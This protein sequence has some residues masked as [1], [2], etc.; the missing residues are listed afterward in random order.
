MTSSDVVVKVRGILRRMLG[1]RPKVG[2]LG[3]LDPMATGV[4]PIAIGKAT[5]LFDIMQEKRKTYVA[6]FKFGVETDT[7]D[8]WGK[9]TSTSEIIPSK[10]EIE[11]VI[12]SLIGEI[13]QYPPAY[14]AK[15][16]NGRRA[17]DLA[18][19]GKA[20][21]IQPKTVEIFNIEILGGEGC[22]FDFKIVCGSGTYIRAIARDMANALNTKAI[23][24]KLNRLESGNFV[25]N[26]SVSLSDFEQNPLEF[27]LPI[28]KGL[29]LIKFELPQDSVFKI[30]NGV[31]TEI[32]SAPAEPFF[33]TVNGE[34]VGIGNN[35]NGYIN[36]QVRLK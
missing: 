20:F 19:E 1:E 18:R 28:D 23:M 21:E 4:L 14:S 32:P 25:I 10:E 36:I 13:S 5:R 30:L 35:L 3:T 22:E 24:T 8:V 16:V 27:V 33:A 34:I 31:A 2:H 9:E 17:Y 15:S 26:D 29:D 12:P 6:T 7:L 11:S